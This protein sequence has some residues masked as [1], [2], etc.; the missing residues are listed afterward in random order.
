MMINGKKAAAGISLFLFI[1]AN[2][3]LAQGPT[4]GPAGQT[5]AAPSGQAS[6]APG[7]NSPSAT[8]AASPDHAR[9]YYHYMLARR[10]KELAGIQ[11]RSDFIER[12]VSEYKQAI[13]ADPDSL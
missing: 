9:A 12:A 7:Q 6:G 8:S 11:N 3:L 10:Y 4:S 13:E 5:P 2:L 1:A